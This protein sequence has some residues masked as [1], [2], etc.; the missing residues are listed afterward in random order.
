[1]EIPQTTAD[2]VLNTDRHEMSALDQLDRQEKIIEDLVKRAIGEMQ[3][4]LEHFI[5]KWKRMEALG[6]PVNLAGPEFVPFW[7]QLRMQPVAT[8]RTCGSVSERIMEL[9]KDGQA[10][11]KDQIA[12]QLNV[13]KKKLSLPLHQLKKRELLM[14]DG[15]GIYIKL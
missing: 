6:Y 11:T 12:A 10:H 15:N 4:E 8:T 3:R 14:S 2:E 1:M 9:F 5:S 7:K 13:E